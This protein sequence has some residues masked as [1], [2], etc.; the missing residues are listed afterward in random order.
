MLYTEAQ[1]EGIPID[2]VDYQIHGAKFYDHGVEKPEHFYALQFRT[3]L[4]R[5]KIC[6]Q[7]GHKLHEQV[8]DASCGHTELYCERCGWSDNFF[9]G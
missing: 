7:H 1:F 5:G 3:D 8:L 6:L 4:E 9:M 2:N